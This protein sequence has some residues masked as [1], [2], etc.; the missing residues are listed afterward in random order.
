[1]ESVPEPERASCAEQGVPEPVLEMKETTPVPAVPVEV[2]VVSALPTQQ[3]DGMLIPASN[4]NGR[5]PA[6]V[7]GL[8]DHILLVR[9]RRSRPQSASPRPKNRTDVQSIPGITEVSE[10]HDA[11]SNGV[12][13]LSLWD[14]ADPLHEDAAAIALPVPATPRQSTLWAQ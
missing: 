5:K 14:L 3:G 10:P 11:N 1:V 12:V 8:A 9:R 7:F 4:G 2:V 6:L 13:M